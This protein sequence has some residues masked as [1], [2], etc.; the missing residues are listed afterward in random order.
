[1]ILFRFAYVFSLAVLLAS[2]QKPPSSRSEDFKETF[3]G[4]ELVDPYHWLEQSDSPETRRWIQAQNGFARQLL[5]ARPIRS[6]IVSRLTEMNKHDHIGAPQL[7]NGYYFFERRGANQDLWSLYR[8]KAS[9]GEDELLLDP[10]RFGATGVS[11]TIFDISD[12]GKLV[13]FGV[14]KGGQDETDLRILDLTTHQELHRPFPAALYRG[15]SFRRDDK[16][17]YYGLEDRETGQRI[18]YHQIGANPANDAE[19]FKQPADTW[20][21]PR[22]SEDG[23]YLLVGVQHGWSRGDIYIQNLEA[24]SALE[25]VVKGL[26]GNFNAGFASDYLFV[27]TDWQA[28]KGRILRIDLRDPAQDKWSEVVP[29]REDAID[30]YSIVGGKLF[31][32]Y[33]HN[34]TSRISIFSLDGT[35]LGDVNLPGIGSAGI[36]GRSD[37]REG[38][39]YV[40]SYTIP[41]SLYRYDSETGK[42]SLWYRDAVPFQSDRFTS[43]QVWYSSKDGT[44]IP[45]FLIHKKGLVPNGKTPTILYGYGGFDVSIT[46]GFGSD[47]AWWIEHGGLY[48]VANIRGGS[49][50]GEDWHRAGMLAKKQNVFDDFIAGAEWLINQHYTSSD[51]LAIWGGSNGGLLVAAALTQRPDLYRAVICWHPDLDM[52]RYYKYTKNNNPPALLEYGNGADPDQFK[53]LL[54]YSPYERVRRGTKYPAVLFESGDADTRVPPEQARK[55]TARLQSATTSDRSIILLYDT[56]AGHAG[57]QTFQKQIDQSADELTFIAWQLSLSP[58]NESQRP[59]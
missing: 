12:D 2:A 15:F 50:F 20:I 14:R 4:Q 49:E 10:H 29:A 52:V 42:L 48:A 57:G 25:P 59:H 5:D 18:L 31:V 9:G 40:N 38:I 13:A 28:P 1:M 17:F 47:T 11:L 54:A 26:N 37:Q 23:K 30:T 7:K 24:G 45:M 41:Y 8:R 33:L 6:Q 58:A 44:K 35:P 36:W 16:G 21:Q 34:V 53:Y 19:V 22:V 39:L 56:E 27:E 43:E 3:H 55:M 32:A 51:K 46:P